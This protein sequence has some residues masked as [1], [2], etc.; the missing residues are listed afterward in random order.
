M[1]EAVGLTAAALAAYAYVPQISHLVHEHC[2][3]GLSGRAFALWLG[4]SML[5]TIH[6]ISIGSAVFIVLGVQQVACTGIV[7][8]LC[9]RYRGQTCPAHDYTA[10]APAPSAPIPFQPGRAESV[11]ESEHPSRPSSTGVRKQCSL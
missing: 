6:A 2:S 1:T 7:A 11:P 10:S 8:F 4:S 9:R 5:M 3:A